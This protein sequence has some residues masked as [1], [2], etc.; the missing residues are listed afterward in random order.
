MSSDRERLRSLERL[1]RE[2]TRLGN[3][4]ENVLRF[5]S[6][7]QARRTRVVTCDVAAEIRHTVSVFEPLARAGRAT[8][9]LELEQGVTAPLSRDAFRVALHNLLDNAVKYGPPGQTVTVSLGREDGMARVVVE[10]QGAGV[11]AA[12]RDTVWRPFERGSDDAA[13]AVGGSGIGLS[14]V[15]DIVD[16]HGGRIAID[17]AEAG[18][19]RFVLE[20]P[21]AAAAERSPVQPTAV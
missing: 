20:F 15:R 16:R 11:P 9:R 21:G 17:A 19:A 14:I 6:I 12:E 3:L 10:D 13:R 5:A 18:G 8:I 7:G 1:D 2:T 4:V